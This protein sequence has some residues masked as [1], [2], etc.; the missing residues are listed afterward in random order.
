VPVAL[1]WEAARVG[2]PGG[3]DTAAVAEL[4]AEFGFRGLAEKLAKLA[5][6]GTAS[7]GA[8]AP[9]DVDYQ[10]IDTPEKLS[11][12]VRHLR[13]QKQIAVAIETGGA[14]PRWAEALGYAFAW[15]AGRAFYLPVRAA[16]GEPHLNPDDTLA[17]LRPV[18][19]DPAVGKVG[20]NLKYA[21]VVLRAAGVEMAGGHFD[22]MVAS[23][24][25]D[26]GERNHSLE[27]LATR[28]LDHKKTN[29]IELTGSG[30]GQKR[31]EEVPLAA[32]ARFAAEEADLTWRLW[33]ILKARLA[34]EHLDELFTTLELP[35]IDV[36]VELESNG[37]RIDVQRLAQLS[38]RYG[39]LLTALE[40]Q[41]YE[42]AGREFNIGSPKQLGQVLFEE[43]KLPMLKKTKTGGSTDVDVLEELALVHPLPAKIIEY[44]QYAKLK[45][46][47][48]DALPQL[49]HPL[50]GRVHTSFNQVVAATGRLSSNDPNLQNIPVRNENGREIRAA[51]LPGPEGWRLLA[52]DYSQVELR[53][54]AHFSGDRTLAEAFARDEDVHARVA[55]QLYGVPLGGVT[56]EMRRAAKA[57]N[58]GVIYGQSPFGLAKQLGIEQ[59]AA[60]EFIDAYFDGYPGVEEFLTKLLE[61]GRR[62]GYV[63]TILGRRRAIRGIRTGAGRQRNLPERTAINTVIQGS[64]ADLIKL[65]MIHIHRRLR[66]DKL[67]A[68][69]LLQIHDE[70]I[71]EVHT[72]D[73]DS[74]AKLVSREMSGVMPLDV[75]LKVDVKSG[76]NWAD[77]EPLN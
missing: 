28:Y 47:Y 38:A 13:V 10:T 51:F 16:A 33:P 60:A 67:S 66:Q 36:L 11:H 39:Q 26:A 63:S 56:P 6:G 71:F 23:Y 75:P 18:L 41:I 17:A 59:A 65:A 5:Q 70:L 19:E 4:C 2:R 25:L 50:T 12:F 54:L 77:C 31:I 57:V 9:A 46:T 32:V 15:E 34:E 37:V 52:A 45:N 1:D 58:F 64:Q 55:T 22:S 27:E 7:P 72:G 21:M 30:K 8:A 53:L 3:I 40:R 61:E 62:K 24:L 44:R 35:L 49:V 42:L 20:H 14:P 69:M 43:H 48:V 29:R 74:L 76:S 68:K 73:L